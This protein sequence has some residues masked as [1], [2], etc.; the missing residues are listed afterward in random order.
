MEG[1]DAR[2]VLCRVHEP[3]RRELRLQDAG[4]PT[5]SVSDRLPPR[6]GVCG[7]GPLTRHRTCRFLQRS[8]ERFL[9]RFLQRSLKRFLKRF[10]KRVLKRFL[11]RL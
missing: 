7:G 1:A 3:T 8:L 6:W 5:A 9:K 10:L 4:K 2:I 11:K